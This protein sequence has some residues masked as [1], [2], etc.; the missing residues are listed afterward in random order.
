M[1]FGSI[2]EVKSQN[3]AGKKR[4]MMGRPAPKNDFEKAGKGPRSL[5]EFT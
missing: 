4:P 1:Y 3:V 5:E 2:L